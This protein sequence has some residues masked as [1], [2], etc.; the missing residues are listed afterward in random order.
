MPHVKGNKFKPKAPVDVPA[1]ILDDDGEVV[2]SEN[3]ESSPTL[4]IDSEDGGPAASPPPSKKAKP[5]KPII[6][7]VLAPAPKGTSVTNKSLATSNWDSL[8][9]AMQAKHSRKS[10]KRKGGPDTTDASQPTSPSAQLPKMLALDCEMVG[11]GK[12]GDRSI[13][14]RVSVVNSEGAVVYD[15]F[16]APTEKVTDYRTK[17]SGVRHSNL[18]DAP[19]F[20]QVKLKVK[21]LLRG[22]VLVGHAVHNDLEVLGIAHPESDL[23][24]TSRYPPLMKVLTNGRIKPRALRHLAQEHLTL[25]IQAAEHCSIEDARASLGLYQKHKKEWE[26]WLSGGGIVPKATARAVSMPDMGGVGFARKNAGPLGA[27]RLAELARSDYM[28]DL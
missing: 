11:V 15:S 4:N 7:T 24:D 16:V 12:R 18:K 26:K 2:P 14:A 8:K 25:A 28:A 21:E 19:S 27:E 22:R 1:E 17:W 13:L 23:R 6:P 3:R 9:A 5:A 20:E 10:K